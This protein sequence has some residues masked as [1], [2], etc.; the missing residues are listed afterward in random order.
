MAIR[1]GYQ[2]HILRIDLNRGTI[3]REAL[4]DE[5]ILRKYVGGT[6]LGLYYLLRE[7][8]TEAQATDPEAPLIFAPGPLTGTPAVNSGDCAVVSLNLSTPYSAAVG[9]MHGFWGAYLK[10]AGHDGIIFTGRASRPT[11]VWIDDDRVEIRDATHLWGQDSRETERLLK[12]ELGD[13]EKISVA[14]V[15]TAGEAL[16]YGAMIK[17][18][19]N[20]GA[21]K[22]SLGAVMGSK[23]LKAVAV[24]G[25]ANVPLFDATGLVNTAAEWESHLSPDN[26]MKDGGNSRNYYD[27]FGK[28]QK[29]IGKN[30]T[31]PEWGSEFARKY[32]QACA[33]WKVTPQPSYNCKVAC[34][35]DVEITDGPYTGFTGSKGGGAE[36]LEGAAGIIGVDD[37][38]GIVILNDV[39]DNVGLE[40]GQ[41]APM[42][43]AVYE[44]Y[45]EGLLTLEDTGGLDLTWGNWES[46]MELIEQTVRREGL[47]A[48]LAQGLKALP[49]ALGADKGIVDEIRNKILDMKGGGAVMHDHRAYWS[50]FLDEMTGGYGPST[51][52]RG[53]DLNARTDLGYTEEKPP[54][55]ASNVDE[56]LD[57]V[58]PVR[59]T[60]IVKLFWDSLAICVVATPT[61]GNL[62]FTSKSLAQAVGWEDFDEEEAWIVGERVANLLRLVYAR[63]GFKKSDELDVSPKFLEI[64]RTG[65]AKEAGIAPY[66]V[67]MVDEYYRQMGW[68]VDTG[69]PTPETLRRLDM[70]EFIDDVR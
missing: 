67:G 48:K 23:N 50:T 10:H 32:V 65:V 35:Y 38:A 60:Q 3:E 41:F 27:S 37:P 66:L 11:Y 24:R 59:R 44:A 15:G 21:G 52:G 42:M 54:G 63:R 57:K 47:G 13:E 26:P 1:G 61:E 58:E 64:T 28:G 19:R 8:P 55:V 4:P 22:G 18:D 40:V 2:P 33:R 56:A 62:R 25:T 9:H 43:G 36:P 7:A 14:C 20:H 30:M 16:L 34:S 69:V 53:R 68:D 5:E 17:N 51:Q 31:D 12:L 29:V 46:A 70:E 39:Y 45:N 6:G 49:Q